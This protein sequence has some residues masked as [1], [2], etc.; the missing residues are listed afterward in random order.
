MKWLWIFLLTF[1]LY[2]EV[3]KALTKNKIYFIS[4]LFDR[5]VENLWK[6]RDAWCIPS[7]H[8]QC[9]HHHRGGDGGVQWGACCVVPASHC[10][11]L[12]V[13]W[14]HPAASGVVSLPV[15]Q[16]HMPLSKLSASN[17]EGKAMRKKT[18]IFINSHG[19]FADAVWGE[20]NSHLGNHMLDNDDWLYPSREILKGDLFHASRSS[21]FC[22]TRT[23]IACSLLNTY[24]IRN[25]AWTTHSL[26]SDRSRQNHSAHTNSLLRWG[27]QTHVLTF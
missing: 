2:V 20:C 24:N 25:T 7:D 12:P 6:R 17:S 21:S 14:R 11:W 18:K 23:V 8:R 16:E 27:T 3:V 15:R 10:Y 13:L 5:Q 4:S 19:E 26:L 1:S 22:L 9:G